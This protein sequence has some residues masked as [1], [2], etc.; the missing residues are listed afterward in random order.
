MGGRAKVR[1]RVK[2]EGEGVPTLRESARQGLCVCAVVETSQRGQSGRREMAHAL[3][4]GT[5][6]GPNIIRMHH[7]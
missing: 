6:R 7:T 5:N 4:I 3:S 2:G 1:V